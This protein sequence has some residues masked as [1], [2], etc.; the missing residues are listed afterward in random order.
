MDRVI[1]GK[2]KLASEIGSGSFG[3]IYRGAN[4]ITH[5]PVAIKF[6]VANTTRPNL[7]LEARIY[8]LLKGAVGFPKMLFYGSQGDLNVMVIDLLGKSLQSLVE[9]APP[10]FSLKTVLMLADQMIARL[11]YLHSKG[12][13]HRDV[14]PENFVMGTGAS[15]NVVYLIDF[16]LAKKFSFET[17]ART[18]RGFVGT[19]KFASIHAHE[20]LEQSRRDDLESLAYTL[21]WML[22]GTLPWS[23][24]PGLNPDEKL[25]KTLDMKRNTPIDELCR[26][27]PAEFCEFLRDVR[28]LEFGETPDY[29]KYQRMFRDLLTRREYVFDYNYDW[30]AQQRP[31]VMS[32]TTGIKL[33]KGGSENASVG[34]MWSSRASEERE[35]PRPCINMRK[36]MDKVNMQRLKIGEHQIQLL[37]RGPVQSLPQ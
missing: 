31:I 29:S 11:W 9:A 8:S 5:Q 18:G 17:V 12:I 24:P 20:G 32:L 14:K 30:C 33:E 16:G 28:E 19:A 15:S 3:T 25:Q 2:Y 34:R 37:G 36:I 1:A 26:G 27:I 7:S 13:I 6:E 22:K 35:R 21:I 23:N 4:M 10:R